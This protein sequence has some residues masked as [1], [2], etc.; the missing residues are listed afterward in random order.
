MAVKPK[1]WKC[2]N[3]NCP[4]LVTRLKKKKWKNKDHARWNIA[5]GHIV[6]ESWLRI[7]CPHCH[8]ELRVNCDLEEELD[9]NPKD[10]IKLFGELHNARP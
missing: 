4:F 6:D 9:M 10:I 3:D 5:I 7:F 2:L 1:F 8:W